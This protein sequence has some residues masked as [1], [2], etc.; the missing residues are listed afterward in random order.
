[1]ADLTCALTF[2]FYMSKDLIFSELG[3]MEDHE[4]PP[5]SLNTKSNYLSKILACRYMSNCGYHV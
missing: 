1:M 2:E 4:I 3:I 5:C